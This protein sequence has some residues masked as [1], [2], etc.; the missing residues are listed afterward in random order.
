VLTDPHHPDP[1]VV[2][3]GRISLFGPGA[4]RLHDELI[5]VGAPWLEAGGP[6]HCQPS[7]TDDH[8]QQRLTRLLREPTRPIAPK[9][10]Q[11][12]R[13]HAAQ[14]FAALWPHVEA[15][16]D[17]RAHDAQLKLDA[18]AHSEQAALRTILRDQR[19]AIEDRTEQTVLDL[20][21]LPTAAIKQIQ[22]DAA[23]MQRRL[24]QLDQEIQTEPAQ[25]AE[26]Y[27]IKRTRVE[28]VGLVYLWPGA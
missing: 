25:L 6:A 9:V 22:D 10:A 28:P 2:A 20:D 7:A 4:T 3:I 13:P 15:E 5:Y 24:T 1:I 14:D 11:R 16:A 27:Q 26:L 18:R 12:L 17:A 21:Q 19:S 23:H 8:T